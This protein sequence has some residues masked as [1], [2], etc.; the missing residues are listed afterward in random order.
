MQQNNR[1]VRA[2][3]RR[4]ISSPSTSGTSLASLDQT[5]IYSDYLQHFGIPGMK[6]GIRRYQNEDGTLTEEGKQR[7]SDSVESESKN[8]KKSDAKNLSDEELNRRNSRLQREKQYKDLT[9]SETER[10]RKQIKKD[11]FK[12]ALI[13]PIIGIAAVAGKKY[14]GK[15]VSMIG[16]YA[17][18]KVAPL[19]AAS[20]IKTTLKKYPNIPDK[21]AV[22]Q[23]IF[24]KHVGRAL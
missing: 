17:A 16:H 14:V 11:L 22:V 2:V 20:I 8:W 1:R 10:E 19:K 5:A 4:R 12:K 24:G 6:W 9:T 18:K 21:S 23:E 3:V 7:Y 13:L 15:A